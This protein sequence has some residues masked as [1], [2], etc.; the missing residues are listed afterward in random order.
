M[1]TAPLTR[2]KLSPSLPIRYRV[3]NSYV[4]WKCLQ[5][6]LTFYFPWWRLK[7]WLRKVW[8]KFT[9]RNFTLSIT[10]HCWTRVTIHCKKSSGWYYVLGISKNQTKKLKNGKKDLGR[11]SSKMRYARSPTGKTSQTHGCGSKNSI[12]SKPDDK[13]GSAQVQPEKTLANNWLESFF[14]LTSRATHQVALFFCK[15][16]QRFILGGEASK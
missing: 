9:L 8:E 10:F 16:S 3:M 14:N 5:A 4:P 2:K 7:D 11:L 13:W 6:K 1:P 15:N 12:R